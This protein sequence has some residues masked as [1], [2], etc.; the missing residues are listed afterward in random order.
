MDCLYEITTTFSLEEYKK[1]T[2]TVSNNKMNLIMIGL[3]SLFVVVMGIVEKSPIMF[4]LAVIYPFLMI[5]SQKKGL[6]RSYKKNTAMHDAKILHRF[7]DTYFVTVVNDVENQYEYEKLQ[8]IIE[9]ETNYYL[10]LS[11]TQGFVIIKANMPEGLEEFLRG[12]KK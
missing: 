6:E 11:K 3:V 8:R 4:V 7:Y 9:T 5:F 2:Q 1:F 12:L 10:M